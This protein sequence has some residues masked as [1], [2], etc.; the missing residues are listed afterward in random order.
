MTPS[1]ALHARMHAGGFAP[2]LPQQDAVRLR[3]VA[4]AWAA[5]IDLVHQ[6]E[7]QRRCI[8]RNGRLFE[9]LHHHSVHR[10]GTQFANRR[11]APH[12]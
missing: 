4:E 9:P 10:R 3:L 11:E 7:L 6:R 8:C 1:Q 5:P 12:V 2:L